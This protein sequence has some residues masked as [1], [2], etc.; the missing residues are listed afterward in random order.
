MGSSTRPVGFKACVLGD[1]SVFSLINLPCMSR[2]E[3]SFRAR[4]LHQKQYNGEIRIDTL[5]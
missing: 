1:V 4:A 3:V 5:R 2:I